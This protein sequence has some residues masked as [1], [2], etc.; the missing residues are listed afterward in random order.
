MDTNTPHQ[1]WSH[2]DVGLE[3]AAWNAVHEEAR[4]GAPGE[5]LLAAQAKIAELAQ[6]YGYG[7]ADSHCADL[8]LVAPDDESEERAAL[9]ESF[10]GYQDGD[11]WECI[12]RSQSVLCDAVR[13][14]S[15]E[16]FARQAAA[17]TAQGQRDAFERGRKMRLDAEAQP[18]TPSL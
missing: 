13:G 17:E 4:K 16:A 9:R 14:T 5:K 2:Y 11:Y 1:H 10:E 3:M 6:A 18:A 15:V 7:E 8:G 12:D